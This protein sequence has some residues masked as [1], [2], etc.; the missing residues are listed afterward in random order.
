MDRIRE[1]ERSPEKEEREAHVR[2]DELEKDLAKDRVE[3]QKFEWNI[4]GG[5]EVFRMQRTLRRIWRRKWRE[6]WSR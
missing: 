2:I 6:L 3:R 4:E 5:G 1:G